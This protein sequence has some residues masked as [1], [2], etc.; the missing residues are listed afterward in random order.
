MR[1]PWDK[2][3]DYEYF[4]KKDKDG[5]DILVADASKKANVSSKER[6]KY[7]RPY[8]IVKQNN[9]M[10]EGYTFYQ[11]H[12]LSPISIIELQLCSPTNDKDNSNLYQNPGWSTTANEHAK[13]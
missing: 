5:K 10:W 8:Q 1:Q 9:D 7:I 6:S 3:R 12:Y 4:K 11:A 2:I 13:N